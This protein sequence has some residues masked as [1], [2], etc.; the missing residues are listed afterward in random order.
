MYFAVGQHV[1][2]NHILV[3]LR[4]NDNLVYHAQ[5]REMLVSG[6]LRGGENVYYFQPGIRYYFYLQNVLFGE[7]SFI[8]GVVSVA[9][10]G[11]GILI[12]AMLLSS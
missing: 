3:R 6:F 11:T 8:T 7:S 5:V 12:V 10:M 4:G 9:L 2:F 1:A